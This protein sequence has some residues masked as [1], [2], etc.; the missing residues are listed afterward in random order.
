MIQREGA[1]EKR[2]W[3][4]LEGNKRVENSKKCNEARADICRQ[5]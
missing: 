2:G 4:L 5:T 1:V 3:M